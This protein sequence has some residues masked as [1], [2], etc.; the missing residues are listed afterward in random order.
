VRPVVVHHDDLVLQAHA[1]VEMPEEVL[2]GLLVG[3][4]GDVGDQVVAPLSVK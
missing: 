2:D 1:A 4:V 3:R